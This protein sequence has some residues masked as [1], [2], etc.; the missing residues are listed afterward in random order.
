MTAMDGLD[1][2][3]P[4]FLRE[5]FRLRVAALVLLSL[6]AGVAAL[7]VSMYKQSFTDTAIVMVHSDRAGLQMRPGTV[8]KLRG[9]DVGKTGRATLNPDGT[10]EIELKLKPEMLSQIPANVTASLEQLTA[11]G[12]KHVA[13]EVTGEESG[14]HL[15]AGDVITA[16]HISVEANQVLEDL[17][18]VLTRLEP[19]KVN[20]ML[21]AVSTALY[22]QG[23][24]LGDTI[25]TLNDYLGRL[26]DD[27]PTIG[28]DFDKASTVLSTYAE[29]TPA[30]MALLADGSVFADSIVAR[31]G[32]LDEF[33]AALDNVS[34][35]GT[36]FL[37]RNSEPL[38]DLLASSLPT[39]ELLARYSP[40]I[41]CFL[42]GMDR[43]NL[44]GERN[45]GGIVPGVTAIVSVLSGGN[46]P[47]RNPENLPV[48]GAD[49]GPR[50]HGMPEYDGRGY[51]RSLME[52]FDLGGDPN[53]PGPD[54]N[55][56]GISEEPLAVQLFGPLASGALR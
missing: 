27:M 53:P 8:V 18:S 24:E 3:V 20:A 34:V 11:F 31:K 45:F 54:E 55:D 10:A 44:L 25:D 29:A 7:T 49:V 22:G 32:Q 23:D 5:T 40:E 26:I 35:D 14:Q 2:N 52:P 56:V 43:A 1:E 9:V 19:A 51:P 33:L 6:L 47:Y 46:D 39:T 16:S 36:V 13:L 12:N 42:K 4:F 28:R 50:C 17:A 48:M 30:L 21:S 41:S 37:A 38:I 15:Q